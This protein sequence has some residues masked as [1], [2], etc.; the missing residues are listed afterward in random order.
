[1]QEYQK[2]SLDALH[3]S[4]NKQIDLEELWNASRVNPYDISLVNLAGQKWRFPDVKEK[5]PQIKPHHKF[6][7]DVSLENELQSEE[8]MRRWLMQLNADEQIKRD[9]ISMTELRGLKRNKRAENWL[10]NEDWG[11]L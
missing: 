1:M 2:G 7:R 8:G 5:K 10:V 6:K 4:V 9:V 3:G 11:Y